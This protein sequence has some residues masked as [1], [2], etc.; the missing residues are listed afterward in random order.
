MSDNESIIW[1]LIR[2]H[3][4]KKARKRMMENI[5]IENENNKI[6][7]DWSIVA[8][9]KETF[10]MAKNGELLEA[11]ID[12]DK[13]EMICFPGIYHGYILTCSILPEYRNMKNYNILLTLK[14]M[15][16]VKTDG[17]LVYN[18]A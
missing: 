17:I 7:G 2:S 3:Q 11:D 15:H 16:I 4:D 9:N 18:L 10:N 6:V 14:K 5:A 13:T 12:I 1:G 8:L